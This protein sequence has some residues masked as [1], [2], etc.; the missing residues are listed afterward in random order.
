M[1]GWPIGASR[2]N[3]WTWFSHEVPAI[4]LESRAADTAYL[5]TRGIEELVAS[6]FPNSI[7]RRQF[8][9][10]EQCNNEF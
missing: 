6:A 1:A 10:Q 3:I 9:H 2:N 8:G 5:K 7:E 4:V